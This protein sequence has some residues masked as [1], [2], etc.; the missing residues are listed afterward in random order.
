MASG[1][2]MRAIADTITMIAPTVTRATTGHFLGTTLVDR[3]C[4]DSRDLPDELGSRGARTNEAGASATTDG[5][6]IRMGSGVL[7]RTC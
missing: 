2:R 7:S 6:G 3:G 5:L 1:P 4:S